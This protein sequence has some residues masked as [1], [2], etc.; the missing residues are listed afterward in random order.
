MCVP[1]KSEKASLNRRHSSKDIQEVRVCY[2]A[3][4][5]ERALGRRDCECQGPEAGMCWETSEAEAQ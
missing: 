5:G 4:E 2:V 3:V 1:L